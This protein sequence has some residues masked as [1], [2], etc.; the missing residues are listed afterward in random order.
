[1][2]RTEENIAGYMIGSYIYN[3]EETNEKNLAG[4][5]FFWFHKDLGYDIAQ[6]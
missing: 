3:K 1:M 4:I 2:R 5:G 6:L